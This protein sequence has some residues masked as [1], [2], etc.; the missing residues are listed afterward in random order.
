LPLF[1]LRIQ[2]WMEG[3]TCSYGSMASFPSRNY[4]QLRG[5]DQEYPKHMVLWQGLFFDPLWSLFSW[6]WNVLKPW[7]K[8]STTST[9]P[10]FFYRALSKKWESK[11]WDLGNPG[12]FHGFPK[13]FRPSHPSWSSF[14]PTH[15]SRATSRR[16]SS[17][18][19][20]TEIKNWMLKRCWPSILGRVYGIYGMWAFSHM[21]SYP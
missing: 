19:M 18:L 12:G 20:K 17:T 15:R 11:L 5:I 9:M 21:M 1:L 13:I 14:R 6:V 7:G 3:A 8:N 2:W 10:C 4:G 16:S